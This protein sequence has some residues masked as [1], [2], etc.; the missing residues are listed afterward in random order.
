MRYRWMDVISGSEVSPSRLPICYYPFKPIRAQV[1]EEVLSA[2]AANRRHIREKHSISGELV[3][4]EGDPDDGLSVELARRLI[5]R[6][7]DKIN[8][9]SGLY[10]ALFPGEPVP[11]SGK[12]PHLFQPGHKL[13]LGP[14]Q[15]SSH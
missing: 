5:S 11:S 8:S 14:W 3:S 4:T 13:I 9:W 15:N 12:V 10:G 7:Q 2:N 1:L 6:R